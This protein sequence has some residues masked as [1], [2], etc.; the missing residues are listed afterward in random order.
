LAHAVFTC[1]RVLGTVSA[2]SLVTSCYSRR[3]SDEELIDFAPRAPASADAGSTPVVADAGSS[4]AR[5]A[6]RDAA[7]TSRCTGTDAISILLCTLASS[8]TGTSTTPGTGSS[9]TGGLTDLIGL[10]DSAGGL[11]SIAAVLA[12]FTGTGRPTTADAGAATA[13]PSLIDLINLA[14]GLGNIATLLNGLFGATTTQPGTTMRAASNPI[15]ELIASFAQTPAATG[16]QP[17]MSGAPA[18]LLDWLTSLGLSQP[19]SVGASAAAPVVL[20]TAADCVAPVDSTTDFVCQL[21]AARAAS[22]L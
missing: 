9:S 19:K 1:V 6:L 16:P 11:E 4:D 17:N 21:G 15:A 5:S 18:S 7:A 10:L 13:Q 22:S 20:P 2:L 14:G 3:T 8:Q 12:A